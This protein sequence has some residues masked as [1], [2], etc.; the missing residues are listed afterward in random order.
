MV[1]SIIKMNDNK[2]KVRPGIFCCDKNHKDRKCM[3]PE[4]WFD[5]FR[6]MQD[7]GEYNMAPPHLNINNGREEY[8]KMYKFLID[9]SILKWE[10]HGKQQ[11]RINPIATTFTDMTETKRPTY[12][13]FVSVFTLIV[14]NYKELE[15]FYDY[16]RKNNTKKTEVE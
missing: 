11:T 2:I 12:D 14:D 13:D 1:W 9:H 15:Q 6:I 7:S 10:K 8:K 5:L 4:V 3:I 16:S